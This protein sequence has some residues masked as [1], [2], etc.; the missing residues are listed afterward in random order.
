MSEDFIKWD[1]PPVPGVFTLIKVE[2]AIIEGTEEMV[3][4][5]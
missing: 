3:D 4:I 1:R 2:G 5:S